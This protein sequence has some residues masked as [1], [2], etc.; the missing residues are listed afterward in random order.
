MI[1]YDF[2]EHHPKSWIIITPVDEKRKR[3][4]NLIF[5]RHILDI[6]ANFELIGSIGNESETYRR[7]KIYD[8]FILKQKSKSWK[9]I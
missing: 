8:G 2:I 6:E 3:L 9:K 5:Q 1:I 7:D 4:Y